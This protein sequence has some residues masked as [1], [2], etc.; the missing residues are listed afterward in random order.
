MTTTA[1]HY[2]PGP[3]TDAIKYITIHLTDSDYIADTAQEIFDACTSDAS[4]ETSYNVIVDSSNSFVSVD[5]TDIS[6][7][8]GNFSLRPVSLSILLIGNESM[9]QENWLSSIGYGII[10][11]C[12]KQLAVW[13]KQYSIPV[14]LLSPEQIF[15]GTDKGIITHKDLGLAYGLTVTAEGL[16]GSFPWATLISLT[17][18]YIG[19]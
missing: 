4:K 11:N 6:H 7:H 10:N 9:T 15:A 16:G 1:L 13:S 17:Q 5:D 8:T 12:A 2:T 3:R 14:V 19:V 18:S